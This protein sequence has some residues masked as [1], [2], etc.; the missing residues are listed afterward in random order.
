MDNQQPPQGVRAARMRTAGE[1]AG[2]TASLA[3]LFAGTE[4]GRKQKE[5]LWERLKPEVHKL[6]SGVIYPGQSS[7]S[8]PGYYQGAGGPSF[9]LMG[10]GIPETAPY[11]WQPGPSTAAY[12]STMLNRTYGL[13][14]D[15]AGA[16]VAQAQAPLR[17]S[18]MAGVRTPM[19]AGEQTQIA[20]EQMV[21]VALSEQ[22]PNV[23]E[24]Q[25]YLQNAARL[26]AYNQQRAQM[27][28]QTIG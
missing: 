1:M 4:Y 11:E 12:H 15:I 16:M 25:N 17:L 22:M 10:G 6:L 14:E 27:L 3:N 24:Q 13:P 9:N 18:S 2:Y 8:P 7:A 20:P 23:L 21:G 19:A 5:Q 28:G 26:A